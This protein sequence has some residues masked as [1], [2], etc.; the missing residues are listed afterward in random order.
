ML[1][2]NNVLLKYVTELYIEII[3]I[4]YIT[5]FTP[6]CYKYFPPSPQTAAEYGTQFADT[7]TSFVLLKLEFVIMNWAGPLRRSVIRRRSCVRP[8]LKYSKSE[9]PAQTG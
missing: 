4:K 6:Y 9:R 8:I 2:K 3:R 1:K 7:I 5:F